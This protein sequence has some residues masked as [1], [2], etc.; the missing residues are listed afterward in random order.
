MTVRTHRS[1]GRERGFT[2]VEVVV[3]LTIVAGIGSVVAL[4]MRGFDDTATAARCRAD[5]TRLRKAESAYFLAHDTYADEGGLV[6]AGLLDQPSELHDAGVAGG[7]YTISEVGVCIGQGTAYGIPAPTVGT[8]AHSGTTV[9]V[10]APDGHGVAGAT[11]SYE[12]SG[13]SAWTVFGATDAHGNAYAP[14]PDGVYDLRVEYDGATDTLSQVTVT[15]GTVVTFPA[16]PLTVRLRDGGGVGHAGGAVTI[17]AAGGTTFAIGTTPASGDLVV[18]VLPAGYDISLTYAGVTSTRSGVAVTAATTVTFQLCTTVVRLQAVDGSG[19][20]FGSVTATPS[21]GG[22]ALPLGTTDASGTVTAVLLDGTYDFTMRYVSETSTQTVTI[23]GSPTVTF[24]MVTVTAHLAQS[25]G[26][27]ISGG[28]AAMWFRP[29]GAGWFGLG[30]PDASGNAKVDVLPATYDFQAVWLG[31][32][33]V[34]SAVAV[35]GPTTVTLQTSSV[36]LRLLASTGSPLSGQDAAFYARAA[37]TP[38][39]TAV[40]VPDATGTAN[41]ELFPGA[42]DFEARWFGVFSAQLNVSVS[43]GTTVTFRTAPAT[44]VL[45]AS[46]NAGLSGQDAAFF[47]RVNGTAPW[48]LTGAPDASGSAVQELFPGTYDFETRWF[49]MFAGQ[50]AVVVSTSAPPTI[51]FRTAPATL[52]LLASTGAG[53][54]GQDGAFF[55]RPNGALPWTLSGHPDATGTVV[56]ELLP[57]AYDVDARWFAA[58]SVQSAVS[59]VAGQPVTVTFQTKL[60]TLRLLSSGGS[61]LS[62]YD[63]AIWVRPT[64]TTPWILTGALDASGTVAQEL[65]AGTY[66]VEARWFG[67]FDSQSAVGVSGPTTVAFHTKPATL[68]MVSSTGPGLAGQDESMWVRQ[69]GTSTWYQTATPVNGVVPQELFAGTYDVRSRWFGVFAQQSSVN[70]NAGATVTFTSVPLTLRMLTSSGSG[71]TGQDESIWVR[72]SG[73]GTYFPLGAPAANGVLVQELFP[74]TYDAKFRWTASFAI[75]SSNVVSGPTT[76]TVSAVAMVMTCRR[77]SDGTP[78]SG[79][80]GSVVNGASTFPFGTSN[81]SGVVNVQVWSG[82]HDFRCKLGALQGTNTNVNAP[83]G[84]GATTVNMS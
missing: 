79:A 33:A 70:V 1:A 41:V 78:V 59:V 58:D 16:V 39:W 46:T 44:S 61:G 69:S 21:G 57:G 75:S 40:G 2:L 54:T 11:A 43:G 9:S 82:P 74:S 48:T 56:Q 49:G 45:L 42:Y 68:R 52:Q 7:A 37:G 22:A 5:T 26:A 12:R 80:T 13:D 31:V 50:S 27:P 29:A 8:S 84:G 19:M 17:T 63:G 34:R 62:G 4:A 28:D 14:L 24:R 20:P 47:F 35:N 55:V 15:S 72:Q 64:G 77:Q 73:G 30:P 66:D 51:T 76:V 25:N 32:T 53:L 6:A 18:N 83:A 60:A 36:P 71:L 38:T 81:A 67:A 10:I 3:A 65:L 23:T